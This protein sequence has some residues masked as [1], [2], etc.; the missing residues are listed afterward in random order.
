MAVNINHGQSQIKST[1]ADLKL[2]S[3]NG[4]VSASSKR[5]VDVQDP[6]E[7]QDAVTKNYLN[8]RISTITGGNDEIDFTYILNVLDKLTPQSPN[9]IESINLDIKNTQSYRITDFVQT[10]N[11]GSGLSASAGSTVSNVLRQD[12]YVT[13]TFSDVGPGDQGSLTPYH[14]GVEGAAFDFSENTGDSGISFR[15]G[16]NDHVNISNNVDY[17]T[18]TGDALGFSQ[19][20]NAYGHGSN[21]P[22]GWNNL[23]WEQLGKQTN[24]TEWYAD[25]SDPGSPEVTNIS[26][27]PDITQNLVY[28]SSVPHYTNNQIFNISFDVNRLSGDFYPDSDTFITA[29]NASNGSGLKN[30]DSLTYQSQNIVTPLVRNYLVSSGSTQINTTTNVVNGTGISTP[31][32]GPRMTVTNSYQTTNI[33][34][35][36]SDRILYMDDDV[37]IGY[38]IDETK[39]LVEN[40]GFGTGDAFRVETVDTDNPNES[41]PLTAWNGELST[42]NNYDATVVGGTASHDTT[43]YS[44]GYLPVGPDLSSRSGPQYIQFKFSRTAVSKFGILWSGKVSGCWVRLPGTAIDASSSINGWVDAS[45]PYEGSGIPGANTAQNGNGTNGCGL[46]S[47]ITLGNTVSN[48]QVDITFGIESSSNATNNDIMVRFKL[49][50]SD[51]L[52]FLK[53]TEA[54]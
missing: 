26:V 16:R 36:I 31:N 23:Y 5:V 41:L 10:D 30:T 46:A 17:G 7:I 14:N 13:N 43:D 50:P 21:V 53:F 47:V 25:L 37:T 3:E 35:N 22:E 12:S 15:I 4:N 49:E 29:L 51:N 32:S 27:T 33:D 48:E 11:T 52:T 54:N 42:L 6:V 18:I 9:S 19:S 44:S 40:V 45:L 8:Q 34:V 28:S 38:P 1:D 24:T 39:I 2:D 20:Y